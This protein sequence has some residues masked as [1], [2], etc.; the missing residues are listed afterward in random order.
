MMDSQ[1]PERFEAV[2]RESVLGQLCED[3]P[4]GLLGASLSSSEEPRR[5]WV[6]MTAASWEA[7]PS[8]YWSFAST[9]DVAVTVVGLKPGTSCVLP[10]LLASTVALLNLN[11]GRAYALYGGSY[12]PHAGVVVPDPPPPLDRADVWLADASRII[13]RS[14]ARPNRS[15]G[16][17]GEDVIEWWHGDRKLTV[18]LDDDKIDYLKVW[19]PDVHSQMQEGELDSDERLRELW[20]WLNEP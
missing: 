15:N 4:I 17:F 3:D 19:G 10:A 20:A 12:T 6:P 8:S 5:R 7:D 18:Y 9:F 16:S 13:G 11:S 1:A 14:L 2:V